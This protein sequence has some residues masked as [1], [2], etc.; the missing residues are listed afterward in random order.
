MLIIVADMGSKTDYP[1]L[2]L[3]TMVYGAA[4][5]L[6]LK[7]VIVIESTKISNDDYSLVIYLF[8]RASRLYIEK[9]I[10]YCN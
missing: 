2:Y 9:L 4:S 5:K 10:K 6:G 8:E 3:D 1:N 7:N